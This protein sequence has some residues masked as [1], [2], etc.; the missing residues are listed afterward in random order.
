MGISRNKLGDQFT[1]TILEWY[2]RR[3]MT[4][5]PLAGAMSISAAIAAFDAVIAMAP[6]RQYILCQKARVIR[7]W[8]ETLEIR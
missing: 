1:F 8:P 4:D 7:K 2:D 5:E 6:E 3:P